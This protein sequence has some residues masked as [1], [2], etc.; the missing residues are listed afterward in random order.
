MAALVV[1]AAVAGCS[2]AAPEVDGE[3]GA[4]L[5]VPLTVFAAAS[6]S[7][8]LPELGERYEQLHPG[9]E[10]TFSFAGSQSL[11]AQVQQGAPADVLVTADES[12]LAQARDELA[13][14]GEVL[15]RNR[16]S[17]VTEPGN[18]EGLRGLAD[19]ARPGLKVVLAGP[20]VPAGKA[21]RK[22]LDAAGVRVR[23]VSEEADVKAVLQKVRLG[24]ADAGVVYAT[25]VRAAGADVTG[26]DLPGVSNSL[27]G[28][29]VA[30]TDQPAAA[31]ALLDLAQ[32]PEGRRLFARFGFL[33]P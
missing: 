16:L 26:I 22:A 14:P 1:V 11:V 19:L 6:L 4:T 27:P 7:E 23:P 24:E 17:V 5:A 9:A 33:P 18:P 10:V 15:A 12:S 3:A 25:D 2:D 30:G 32:S 31:R 20:T 29:V 21:A 28:A 8:V 13:G